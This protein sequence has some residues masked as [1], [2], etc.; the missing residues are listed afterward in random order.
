VDPSG[1]FWKC[2]ATAIG[3]SRHTVEAALVETW[4]ANMTIDEAIQRAVEAVQ[5]VVNPERRLFGVAVKKDTHIMLP[6]T[7]KML[8]SKE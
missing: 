2:H 8:I 4:K 1:Q 6:L 3:R 5:T 7:H